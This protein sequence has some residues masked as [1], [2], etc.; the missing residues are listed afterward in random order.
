[1]ETTPL[2][3]PPGLNTDLHAP[4]EAPDA[5]GGAGPAAT[6]QPAPPELGLT[7]DLPAAPPWEPRADWWLLGG[8]SD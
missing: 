1:M 5:A 3:K 7:D 6:P 2:G 8:E 4:L